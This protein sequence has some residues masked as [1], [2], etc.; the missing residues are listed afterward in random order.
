MGNAHMV[1]CWPVLV[2]WPVEEVGALELKV[3]ERLADALDR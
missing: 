1:V 3:F 2:V